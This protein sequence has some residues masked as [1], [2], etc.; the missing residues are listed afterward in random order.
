MT[1]SLP[2]GV[3][4]AMVTPFTDSRDVDW[5]SLDRLVEWYLNTGA[6]GLFPVSLSS[7]M[8][9]LTDAERVSIVERV[10]DVADGRVPVIATGTFGRQISDEAAFVR[11]LSDTGADAIVVNAAEMAAA[12]ETDEQWAAR[13]EQL[14]ALTDGIPLGLYECPIPYHRLVSTK[15]LRDVAATDR[16]VFVKDTCCDSELLA[17]RVNAVAATSIGLYN[18]NAPLLLES[19]RNGADG[20]CGI[21]ANFY[22]GLLSWLCE[23]YSTDPNVAAALGRF[24]SIADYLVR[25]EY[26]GGAKR[27]LARKGV[28]E[29]VHCRS[30]SDSVS[31]DHLATLDALESEI[32][33]WRDRLG[34]VPVSD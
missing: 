10:V 25:A 33:D 4:P 18:A 15:T 14:L 34:I 26:P 30:T 16:F 2:S 31:E 24:L 7:E 20:Y 28:I 3:W 8:Y 13:I 23:N 22:P 17:E 21:A 29:T 11:R 12:A 32:E 6:D 9:E 27:Y 19:L 1:A 5:Q